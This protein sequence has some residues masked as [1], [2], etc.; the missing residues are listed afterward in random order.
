MVGSRISLF[1]LAVSLFGAAVASGFKPAAAIRATGQPVDTESS[2]A[3]A[4]YIPSYVDLDD[5]ITERQLARVAARLS[6]Q[7][8]THSDHPITV[9]HPSAPVSRLR[10]IATLV[11]LAV[12]GNEP[13]VGEARSE[14]MPPDAALIPAWGCRFV[15]SAVEQGW[16]PSDR[17]L[18]PRSAA[19]WNFVK[20]VLDRMLGSMTSDNRESA[21][22]AASSASDTDSIPPSEVVPDSSPAPGPAPVALPSPGVA[23]ASLPMP[24]AEP[25]NTYTGLIL[26]ARGLDVQRAMGPRI[27]DEDGRVL[28]PDPDHVPDM[29][30][31]Q[32]HGMAAYVKDAQDTPRSGSRPLTVW[33]VRLT[34]PG[35]ADL[36]VSREASR[37]IMEAEAQDGFLSRWAVSILVNSH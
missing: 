6:R 29:T 7:L 27:I 10:V 24:D 18:H 37:R 25:S 16:W 32:D 20:G 33:V 11:K 15:A 31:L 5:A 9:R 17:P 2:S 4:D 12:T 35:H 3:S 34:G 14:Q 1:G 8:G 21:S 19:S 13:A 28:Y 23:P 36:V 22:E 30:F 26:D